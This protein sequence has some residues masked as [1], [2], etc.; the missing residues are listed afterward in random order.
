MSEAHNAVAARYIE[1]KKRMH[2]MVFHAGWRVYPAFWKTAILLVHPDSDAVPTDLMH[3]IDGLNERG[4]TA[5]VA[6]RVILFLAALTRSM[7]CS[8]RRLKNRAAKPLS[9]CFL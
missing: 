8:P 1:M 7:L 4:I 2:Y 3:I 6:V 9:G 5:P